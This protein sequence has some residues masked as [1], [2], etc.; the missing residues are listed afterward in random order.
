[1]LRAEITKTRHLTR[2]ALDLALKSNPLLQNQNI[3]TIFEEMDITKSGTISEEE[4]VETFLRA[5]PPDDQESITNVVE[6]VSDFYIDQGNEI[7][8][9]GPDTSPLRLIRQISDGKDTVGTHGRNGSFGFYNT[10]L[11]ARSPEGT[12]AGSPRV[13][14]SDPT[15]DQI[16][17]MQTKIAEFQWE[18]ENLR[19]KTVVLDQQCRQLDASNIS[20]LHEKEE[21]S[22]RYR[23]LQEKINDL[24]TDIDVRDETIS[25]LVT[26][27]ASIE[28]NKFK[29]WIS[30]LKKESDE[31]RSEDAEKM[32]IRIN[33]LQEQNQKL[34]KQLAEN[35]DLLKEKA[36]TSNAMKR[37]NYAKTGITPDQKMTPPPTPG[38]A[39]MHDQ[40]EQ[41]D[42]F[43]HYKYKTEHR[44][45][46]LPSKNTRSACAFFGCSTNVDLCADRRRQS[47]YSE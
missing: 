20:I 17:T 22:E 23:S 39:S 3:E 41:R 44:R 28:K 38:G 15:K 45:V 8:I 40:F 31:K 30:K 36:F 11:T 29:Q 5:L 33:D 13:N 6:R 18:I 2:K 4:F 12:I 24:Q 19:E 32:H 34:R 26:E 46:K 7:K 10:I 25:T 27:I 35:L 37:K 9:N 1:M 21:L 16:F 43:H 47:S 14:H 42:E